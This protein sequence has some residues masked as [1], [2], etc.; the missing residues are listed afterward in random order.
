[1]ALNDQINET[2]VSV[3]GRQTGKSELLRVL[4]QEIF[5][6]LLLQPPD[7]RGIPYV[8][9]DELTKFPIPKKLGRPIECKF[10]DERHPEATFSV[11]RDELNKKDPRH[12]NPHA[13]PIRRWLVEHQGQIIHKGTLNS[14]AGAKMLAR[15]KHKTMV[16]QIREKI[17]NEAAL[18]QL[19]EL[20]TMSVNETFGRF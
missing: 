18:R 2:W 5:D 13:G 12:P 7:L 4:N 11:V 19:E 15:T 16:K 17:E 9:Y 6:T 14:L 10:E 8:I 20:E 3:L 1:M